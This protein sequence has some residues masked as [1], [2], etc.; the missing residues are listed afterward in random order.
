[1]APSQTQPID[2]ERFLTREGQDLS[3]G[4]LRK[5]LVDFTSIPGVIGLHGGLPPGDAF[6]LASLSYTTVEGDKVSLDDAQ[7]RGDDL[8]VDGVSCPCR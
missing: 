1:M 3:Y 6:P 8:E 2:V 4:Q 5:L 7:V